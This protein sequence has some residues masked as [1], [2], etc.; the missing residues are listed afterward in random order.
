MSVEAQMGGRGTALPILSLGSTWGWVVTTTSQ[1]LYHR[2][3]D[4]V[5][6]VQE[7]GR[8]QG[9]VWLDVEQRKSLGTIGLYPELSSLW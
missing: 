8:S 4:Q 9:P 2:E 1:L 3:G 5:P 6:I 7:V